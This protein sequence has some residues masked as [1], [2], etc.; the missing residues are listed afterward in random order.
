MAIASGKG[1]TGK[2]TLAVNLARACAIPVQLL[3]CDVEAPN[4][5]LFLGGTPQTTTPSTMPVPVVDA[6][7]CDGCGACARFCA[8]NAIAVAGT[9]VLI[10]PEL[11]HSCGGCVAVCP[12][13]AL[14]E[15]PHRIGE[16]ETRQAGLITLTLGRLDIGVAMAPPLIHAVQAR[17]QRGTPVIIDAPPGTSCPA[18]AAVR[19]ADVAVLVTEPTPFGLHD[20]RLAV[21]M[22]RDLAVPFGVV[23]NRAGSGDER[24]QTYCGEEGIP[25]LLEIPDDRRIAEAYARGALMIDALPEYR[26]VFETLWKRLELFDEQAG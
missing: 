6:A 20:L 15:V 5:H 24:V 14:R 3:D 23:I 10:F 9:R 1:G 8:Y 21:A 18:V 17:A 16:I 25:V 11:C 12:R 2:T 26:V 4:A 19:G 13:G 7:G 22:V